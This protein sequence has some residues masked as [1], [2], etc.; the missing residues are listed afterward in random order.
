MIKIDKKLLI[1]VFA[2]AALCSCAA[3]AQDDGWFQG[4][5][6]EAATA[7]EFVGE[8]RAVERTAHEAGDQTDAAK[9]AASRFDPDAP[10]FIDAGGGPRGGTEISAHALASAPFLVFSRDDWPGEGKLVLT[11]D[12]AV[13]KPLDRVTVHPAGKNGFSVGLGDTVDVLAGKR[14]VSFKGTGALLAVRAGRGV[15]VGF[16]GK[17]KRQRLIIRMIDVWG[18]VEGG[19][20]I[21]KSKRFAPVYSGSL[22]A[23]EIELQAKVALRID[24][25]VIP[26]MNQYVIIDKGAAD[27][28]RLGDFFRVTKARQGE[29]VFEGQVVN[30]SDRSATL[31]IIKVYS[32]RADIGDDAYLNMRAAE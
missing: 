17:E 13:V 31:V 4:D 20:S 16:S 5:P 18:L 19:E 22:T 7:P 8:S 30:V 3:V 14:R 27:G 29:D 6:A 2:A 24:D 25:T 1:K 11:K 10:A 12:R 23:S 26:Y 15:I 32:E 28:V 21:A 9:A